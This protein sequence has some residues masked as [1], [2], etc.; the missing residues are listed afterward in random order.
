MMMSLRTYTRQF[1]V[2]GD[3]M[4][5]KQTAT[6]WFWPIAE[7]VLGAFEPIGDWFPVEDR[8]GRFGFVGEPAEPDAAS[9]YLRLP[10]KFPTTA[11]KS[12]ANPIRFVEP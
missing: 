6:N 4:E 12:A 11:Q 10:T 1:G 8:P 9:L 3:S 7:L 5:R 2:V